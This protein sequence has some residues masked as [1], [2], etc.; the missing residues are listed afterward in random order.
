MLIY[1]FQV[2]DCHLRGF[3]MINFPVCWV[4]DVFLLFYGGAVGA[5]K[6]SKVLFELGEIYDLNFTPTSNTH[7]YITHKTPT[8]EYRATRYACSSHITLTHRT[9]N[10]IPT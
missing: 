9:T 2:S 3:H 7:V 5:G 10:R 4:V 1:K 8:A 6:G